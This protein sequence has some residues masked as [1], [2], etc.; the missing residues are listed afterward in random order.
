MNNHNHNNGQKFTI[1]ISVIIVQDI[2][3][4]YVY[5]ICVR[6]MFWH[7]TQ[8]TELIAHHVIDSPRR[9]HTWF[10]A[11]A[12]AVPHTIFISALTCVNWLSKLD[13]IAVSPSNRFQSLLGNTP[14]R[15]TQAYT[16]TSGTFTFMV[17]LLISYCLH[18][19]RLLYLSR[20]CLFMISPAPLP[21]LS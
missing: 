18:L 6:Y 4:V 14:E 9:H 3:V 5:G 16:Y 19:D 7:C 12:R 10:N 8:I 20:A 17:G 15:K 1:S 11:P 21:S 13:C 2:E